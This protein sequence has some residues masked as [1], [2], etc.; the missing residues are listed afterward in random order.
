MTKI[1]DNCSICLHSWDD[2][3]VLHKGQRNNSIFIFQRRSFS[4]FLTYFFYNSDWCWYWKKIFH[5]L[6]SQNKS[7]K[8]Q[9]VEILAG[10]ST[11][12]KDYQQ[13]WPDWPDLTREWSKHKF[14]IFFWFDHQKNFQLFDC[15][16]WVE[17][18]I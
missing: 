1:S 2:G 11:R 4:K 13:N 10:V 16:L 18:S 5:I 6:L 7:S 9:I 3:L 12:S 14:R 8:D 17:F 15:E